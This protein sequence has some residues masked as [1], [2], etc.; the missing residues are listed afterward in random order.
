MGFYWQIACED[1]NLRVFII[2]SHYEGKKKTKTTGENMLLDLG[3]APFIIIAVIII[4]LMLIILG[5]GWQIFFIDSFILSIM[6]ITFCY[7]RLL[8]VHIRPFGSKL[9]RFF[10]KFFVFQQCYTC[11]FDR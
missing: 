9:F 3:I 6:S 2:K 7:S 8:P 4:G 5:I 1:Q 11:I 10:S